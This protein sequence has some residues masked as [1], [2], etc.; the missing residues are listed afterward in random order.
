MLADILGDI[1]TEGYLGISGVHVRTF[2]G[3]KVRN[4]EH[5]VE[6]VEGCRDEFFVFGMD[7]GDERSVDIVVDAAESRSATPRVMK[8]YGIPADRSEDLRRD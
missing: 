6:L 8:R 2:N 3:A 7:M 1:S 4:L 5:L